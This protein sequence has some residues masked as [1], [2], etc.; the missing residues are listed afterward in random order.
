M[1]LSPAWIA[2]V[3][4]N[5]KDSNGWIPHLTFHAVCFA[6]HEEFF[7]SSWKLNNPSE[8][9]MVSE[10]EHDSEQDDLGYC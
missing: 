4:C 1:S 9:G 7:Y 5:K 3:L 8:Y 6:L 2:S 10:L